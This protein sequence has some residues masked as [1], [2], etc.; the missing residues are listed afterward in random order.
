M[1]VLDTAARRGH[2][3]PVRFAALLHDL[4]KGTTPREEWPRHT[5]HEMRSVKLVE[6]VS[7]RLKVPAGVENWRCWWRAITAI[8]TAQPNCARIP[9][10]AFWAHDALRR[11]QR[12][13]HCCKPVAD[14]NGRQGWGRK[15]HASPALLLRRWLRLNQCRSGDCQVLQ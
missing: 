13:E 8:S 2:A 1:M 12:F 9:S 11:P 7:A 4:G 3:L 15:T 6:T 14:F 5:A 10:F